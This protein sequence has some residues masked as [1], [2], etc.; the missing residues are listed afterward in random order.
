[1]RVNVAEAVLDEAERSFCAERDRVPAMLERLAV[2]VRAKDRA[3]LPENV[4]RLA[5]R[6]RAKD[7]TF[8]PEKALRLAETRWLVCL[9][10]DPAAVAVADDIVLAEDRTILPA[11]VFEAAEIKRLALRVIV[12]D[13]VLSEAA[14]A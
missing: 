14:K 9:L 2:S 10:I 7:R 8:V 12:P 5:V 4:L 6:L 3:V 11:A 1:V 13:A